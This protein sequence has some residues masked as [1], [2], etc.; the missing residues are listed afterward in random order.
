MLPSS[1][2]SFVWGTFISTS[3]ADELAIV[4]GLGPSRLSEVSGG[5][6]ATARCARVTSRGEY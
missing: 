5:S 1:D 6:S 3:E 4:S 2:D